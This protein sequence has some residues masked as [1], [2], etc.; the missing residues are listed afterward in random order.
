[1]VN[2]Y[3]PSLFQTSAHL[4]RPF[5]DHNLPFFSPIR[6]GTLTIVTTDY[7]VTAIEFFRHF[8]YLPTTDPQMLLIDVGQDYR[9]KELL[10]GRIIRVS[11]EDPLSRLLRAIDHDNGGYNNHGIII[12][13]LDELEEKDVLGYLRKIKKIAKVN[14]QAVVVPL[15]MSRSLRSIDGS[16]VP[17]S[18]PNSLSLANNHMH[19]SRDTAAVKA[20]WHMVGKTNPNT[21]PILENHRSMYLATRSR[22]A[23]AANLVAE[24]EGLTYLRDEIESPVCLTEN[25]LPRSYDGPIELIDRAWQNGEV[26]S[27]CRAAPR[28]VAL[29][30]A[31]LNTI[32]LDDISGY[33]E[34]F[35]G[36][37]TSRYPSIILK[38][39]EDLVAVY[40][41][42]DP[43]SPFAEA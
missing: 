2:Q 12:F 35:K 31:S 11:G 7:P 43:V 1:M 10:D 15:T 21:V 39:F 3:N 14:N 38:L 27:I 18:N 34:A 20:V 33:I 32:S 40:E 26:S 24:I 30:H 42:K 22:L 16:P 37:D 5:F 41:S 19:C 9:T 28:L 25:M 6:R 4:N 8:C 13:G 23:I 17:N 29:E 36:R